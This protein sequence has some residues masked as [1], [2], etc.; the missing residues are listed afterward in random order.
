MA[1][2]KGRQMAA[3]N[4]NGYVDM[5]N[6][7]LRYTCMMYSVSVVFTEV[8]RLSLKSL[9]LAEQGVMEL[10]V[11]TATPMSEVLHHFGCHSAS[12]CQLNGQ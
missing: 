9:E 2:G 5:Y 3:R 1:C 10:L 4:R 7:S 11:N 6:C 8:E 12:H